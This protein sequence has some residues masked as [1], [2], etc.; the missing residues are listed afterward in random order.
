MTLR[1]LLLPIFPV[2][3]ACVATEGAPPSAPIDLFPTDGVP[4]GW[5]VSTWSDVSV[6]APSGVAWTVVDGVLTSPEQRGTWLISDREYGDFVLELEIRLTERGNSG[7]ALR[8]PAAGD[9]AFDGLELQVADVRYNPEATASE[10]TGGIYRAIAPSSQVYR[11][12]DW[13][14]FRVELR[15]P[16]LVVDLNGVRIH[17]LDLRDF[18][19][20]IPRHDGSLAPPIC[21]RPLRGRIGFQHLSRGEEAPVLIRRARITELG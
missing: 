1:A 12:E 15:G 17:D 3:F 7:I 21:D 20:P 11:P 16:R 19:D 9:P 4:A 14:A 8:S 2:L 5:S 18:A 10:I 13:N 6:P